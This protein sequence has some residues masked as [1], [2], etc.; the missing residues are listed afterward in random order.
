MTASIKQGSMAGRI[1]AAPV[2]QP[3]KSQPTQARRTKA[4]PHAI[5]DLRRG[6]Q[7][8]GGFVPR[9]TNAVFEKHG[10][11][12][13][14]VATDWAAIVGSD[15]AAKCLPERL[16]WP[17]RRPDAAEDTAGPNP[18]SRRTKGVSHAHQHEAATLHLVVE[19]AFALEIQYA[20]GQLI[21][22]L[23]AYFGYRAIGQI[24]MRQAPLEH[25]GRVLSSPQQRQ[26]GAASR[27]QTPQNAVTVADT[28]DDATTQ[29]KLSR[30]LSRLG[31]SLQARQR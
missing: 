28:G 19:P 1:S 26:A 16:V 11:A 18:P 5:R 10:F 12:T 8:I 20:S 22:R 30:A 7:P 24:R 21:N 6:A 4:P 23:N 2:S 14:A 13:A 25:A 9:L 29:D 3:P 15:A 31:A 17:K 27:N